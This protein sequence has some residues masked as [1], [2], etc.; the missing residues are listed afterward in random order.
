[1][2]PDDSVAQTPR[3]WIARRSATAAIAVG[4]ATGAFAGGFLIS[5]AAT[6]TASPSA[7]AGS[8]SASSGSGSAAPAPAHFVPNENPT[9]EAGESAAREAQENAGQV[10][11]V[12]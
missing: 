7:S 4:L 10:P 12:P 9:H 3:R 2:A 11:T 8:G 5:H 6:S 1:M